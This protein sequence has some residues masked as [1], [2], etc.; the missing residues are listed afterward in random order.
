MQLQNELKNIVGGLHH[1]VKRLQEMNLK[2]II[3]NFKVIEEIKKE[4]IQKL[5]Q[6]RRV[7][8]GFLFL[9]QPED[10]IEAPESQDKELWK[11]VDEEYKK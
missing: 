3:K 8:T 11:G 1:N 5:G 7:L 2:E 6:N 4:R 10:K 9:T